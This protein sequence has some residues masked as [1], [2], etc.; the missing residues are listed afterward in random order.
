MKPTIF[1]TRSL[2]ATTLIACSLFVS[3]CDRDDDDDVTPAP[4][5]NTGSLSIHVENM[6]D[7]LP[8]T[9]GNSS[10]VTANGD[11]LNFSMYKYY[12]SNIKLIRPDGS[13]YAEAGGYHLINAADTNSLEFTIANVPNGAYSGIEFMIGVD[14]L[15]NVS[16]S[17][18]GALDPANGMFWTWSTGYIMAKMEGSSPQSGAANNS[19]VYHI[20]G[21]SGAN[22]S[23]RMASPSFNGDQANVSSTATPEVHI[24]CDVAEW[25]RNPVTINVAT[26]FFQMAVNANSAMVA[27]N[28]ADMFTVEHIHN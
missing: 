4:T 16:G 3:S 17:Q 6:F 12:I 10:Y 13:H 9:L 11:T 20:G 21:F 26:T 5:I 24:K 15:R 28:Y 22:T 14:S 2:F 1:N 19:I 18:T 27:T 7:T 25:F 23:L 8:F